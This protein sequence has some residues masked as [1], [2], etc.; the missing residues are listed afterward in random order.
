MKVVN[1]KL[2]IIFAI[3]LALIPIIMSLVDLM[4]LYL[5]LPY[6]V[7]FWGVAYGFCLFIGVLRYLLKGGKIDFAKFKNP[8]IIIAISMLFWIILTSIINNAFNIYL[9]I[10]LTYFLIFVCVYMLNIKWKEMML[11]TLL[12]VMA[13]SCL[14]GFVYMYTKSVPGLDNNDFFIALHFANPNYAS[15]IISA[16]AL[17]CFVKFDKQN[18]KLWSAFYLIIYLIYATHLFVNGSFA[19]ITFLIIVEV[20]VQ[21]IL[22]IKTKKCKYKMLV[23]T[24]LLLPVCLLIELLPNIEIIR[25]CRYNYLLE[26]VAVFDNVFGTNLLDKFGIEKIVGSDGWNRNEL[27]KISWDRATSSLK[28]FIFGGGAGLFYKYRPHQ[29]LMS[30]MLDFGVVIPMLLIALFVILII[31]IIK[32]KINISKLALLPSIICFLMCYLTGSILPNSF[33]VFMILLGI[34]FKDIFNKEQPI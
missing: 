34:L 19:G 26:C 27:L 22:G 18:N 32:S 1:T 6:Y 8:F 15:H 5:S 33:Y 4:G 16:L 23:L 17:V 13:I 12:A 9:I 25:T 20:A 11:N 31:K 30:L 3:V 21:I 7:M 28:A 24:I 2:N 29:G 10:Y 14:M